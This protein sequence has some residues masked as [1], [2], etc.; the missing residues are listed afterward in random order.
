MK[1]EERRESL[2][3]A[4][5]PAWRAVSDVTSVHPCQVPFWWRAGSVTTKNLLMQ[6]KKNVNFSFGIPMAFLGCILII[7]F[8]ILL[9]YQGFFFLKV[10][11]RI[12]LL[13]FQREE[14]G[15]GERQS[16]M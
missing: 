3:T 7:I 8:R 12:C 4:R 13:I 15:E 2:E 11:P 16:S 1:V 14:G 5:Y 10:N 9:I 6:T